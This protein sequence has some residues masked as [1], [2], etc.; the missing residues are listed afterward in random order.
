MFEALDITKTHVVHQW[1]YD[2]PLIACRIAPDGQQ[3]VSSSED[4]L[5]QLWKIPSGEKVVL[6]GHES[7]VHALCYSSDSQQLITGGCDGQ[8]IW[9]S[10][11]AETPSIVR[12]IDAHKGWIR[13][14]AISPD[15]NTLVSVGND[16]LVKLWN[17][18]T[19]EKIAE[20]AG[21]QR[22]IYSVIFHPNG[23]QLVTGDLIGRVIVWNLPERK[24][25][26]EIDA[27]PL[28]S[29]NKGQNAEFGGVRSLA[30]S[31]ERNELIASG[32][33]KASNPFGAV[34]EPLLLRFGWEDGVLR[35]THACDGIPGGLL[36]RTQWL[37]DGTAVS[38]SGGSTGG[39][40]LFFKDTQEKE[41]HR[42][43][44]PSL[45]RDMDVHAATNMVATAHY[46]SH[47]RISVMSV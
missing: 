27:K 35:K 43:M 38:V 41:V 17:M 37:S 47:L 14:V 25:E 42:F 15:G 13:A 16:M 31:A 9:W 4:S 8:I 32:T 21:H 24:L 1:K 34:H 28:Y 46:D 40:L 18:A 10:A 36:W 33:H 30:F 39:I 26:R 22:H 44:L 19:G 3:A 12:K 7:W 6:K 20:L 45:A 23:T 5:L 29:E 2:R 11:K